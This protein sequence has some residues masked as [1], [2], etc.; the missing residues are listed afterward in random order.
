MAR[1]YSFLKMGAYTAVP[2][3][4]TVAVSFASARMADRLIGRHG[5][6]MHVRRFFVSAGFLLG[7]TILFLLFSQSSLAV[8]FT[9][10]SSLFGIGLASSNYWALTEAISPPAI[11]DELSDT[12][13]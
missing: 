4:G 12:R 9:L 13:T 2:Y 10:M 3:V 6:P 8:L 7:S 5:R 1:G 11:S